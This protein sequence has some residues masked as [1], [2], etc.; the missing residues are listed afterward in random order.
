MTSEA[1]VA[2]VGKGIVHHCGELPRGVTSEGRFRGA[3]V[4]WRWR[5][6]VV[7]G[8]AAGRGSGSERHVAAEPRR[9]LGMTQRKQF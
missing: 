6:A 5:Q 4:I 8:T 2:R 7:G 1:Y 9:V 3:L